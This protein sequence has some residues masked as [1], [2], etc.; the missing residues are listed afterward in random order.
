MTNLADDSISFVSLSDPP[1][2]PSEF[3]RDTTD[4]TPVTDTISFA[5][6]LPLKPTELA[7][8]SISKK[9]KLFGKLLLDKTA[10]DT[11]YVRDGTKVDPFFAV[12]NIVLSIVIGA[13]LFTTTLTVPNALVP[14]LL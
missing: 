9:Y 5:P 2:N 14:F 6:I 3:V 13:S 1:V 10:D 11:V 7:V 8:I 4:G 12:N